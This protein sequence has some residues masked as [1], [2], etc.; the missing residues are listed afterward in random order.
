MKFKYIAKGKT[1][2]NAYNFPAGLKTGDVIEL[3]G[4]FAEKAKKN[5]DFE[6]VGNNTKVTLTP[7]EAMALR[8]RRD[9]EAATI[10]HSNS[11]KIAELER[12]LRE[13]KQQQVIRQ[14]EGPSV[15]DV[16]MDDSPLDEV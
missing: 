14:E 8:E 9:L 13:L 5:P 3:Q 6:K 11:A 16:F 12:Q 1:N 7:E 2:S 10:K 15:D 4:H